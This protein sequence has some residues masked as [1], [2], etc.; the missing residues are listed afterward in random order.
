MR[1]IGSKFAGFTEF[2]RRKA[3]V[4]ENGERFPALFN[5]GG[6]DVGERSSSVVPHWATTTPKGSTNFE[7]PMLT[8]PH[9]LTPATKQVF[10]SARAL[11]ERSQC[12]S[13]NGPF[14]HAAETT[15][16]SAPAS[17]SALVSSGKRTS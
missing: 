16:R 3:A 1:L 7:E 5:P 15:R 13:F 2:R 12:I 14:T 11:R 4:L 10:S 8:G 6:I 17:A 9:S